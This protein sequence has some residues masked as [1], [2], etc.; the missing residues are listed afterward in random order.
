MIAEI[1]FIKWENKEEKTKQISICRQFATISM[2]AREK[3][4]IYCASGSWRARSNLS[5]FQIFK[6]SRSTVLHF[7]AEALIW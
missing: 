4:G 3:Q 1:G 6:I 5:L 7:V 2:S